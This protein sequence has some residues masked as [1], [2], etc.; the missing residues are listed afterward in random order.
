MYVCVCMCVRM[1]HGYGCA[2]NNFYQCGGGHMNMNL[3]VTKR[4]E[5]C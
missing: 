2:K 5:Q 4:E 1:R 3:I